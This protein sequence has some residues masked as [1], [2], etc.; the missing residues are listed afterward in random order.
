MIVDDTVLLAYVD[1]SL[2]PDQVREVA[3][4]IARSR[5]L[6]ARV[7]AL[8]ASRLPYGEA[9]KRQALP[10]VSPQ[11]GAFVA[12]LCRLG[13]SPPSPQR[14]PECW[15]LSIAFFGGMICCVAFLKAWLVVTA[16]PSPPQTRPSWVEAVAAYQELYP[17]D[18]VGTFGKG[19]EG[20]EKLLG[21]LREH[22]A[23]SV[24]I[25]DLHRLGL[26]FAGIQ[27]LEFQG[28]PLVHVLYVREHG[29]P[30]ALCL[31]R[32]ARPDQTLHVQSLGPMKTVTWRRA[33]LSY[34]LLAR[35][36]VPNLLEIG[37][38]IADGELES[39]Y[40]HLAGPR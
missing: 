13:A 40:G 35:D 11:L 25:P 4:A 37:R 2:P 31:T 21:D 5:E 3:A 18:T 32:E 39:L 24:T 20:A 15:R 26:T 19:G 9:F 33:R 34:V 8:R 36:S 6:A 22:D 17:R 23:M 1:Q 38:Q 10:P 7:A 28:Q 27:R 12:N 16:D 30:V 14:I 29:D